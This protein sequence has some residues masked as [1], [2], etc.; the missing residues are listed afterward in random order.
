[1]IDI[2]YK[3]YWNWHTYFLIDIFALKYHKKIYH[4]NNSN[5]FCGTLN[6]QNFPPTDTPILSI[7]TLTTDCGSRSLNCCGIRHWALQRE[8]TYFWLTILP[9]F[10]LLGKVFK[11]LIQMLLVNLNAGAICPE[12]KRENFCCKS[13]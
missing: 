7:E 2:R 3:V 10:L 11:Y 8:I 5:K 13:Y 6:G 1:M 4:W 9:T 12:K